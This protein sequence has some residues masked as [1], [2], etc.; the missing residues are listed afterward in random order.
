MF[1]D[2]L[3]DTDI[4]ARKMY[5]VAPEVNADQ[6]LVTG[7]ISTPHVDMHGDVVLPDAMDADTYFAT[8]RSVN[9]DHNPT[10]VVGTNR[11]LSA[12]PQGVYAVTYVSKTALGEDVLTM[13]KEG[14]IRGMSI[15]YN[16][17]TVKAS[18][19]TAEEK[20]RYG[21]E[22]K[23]VFRRWTLLGYAFT[24][25]PANPQCV[26]D[27]V[28]SIDGAMTPVWDRMEQLFKAGKIHRSSA[29]AAGFPDAP[30]RK[31]WPVAETARAKAVL[32]AAGGLVW[33]RKA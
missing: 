31:S 20:M 29:V 7:Y 33:R 3:D 8:T 28:K 6:R 32:V 10:A 12:R 9:L 14:V 5:E 25:R 27:G 15:E 26:V 13:I 19:P 24:A 4:L 21:P 11:N 1:T 16:R 18:P 22:C 30:E 23:A 17:R 2:T